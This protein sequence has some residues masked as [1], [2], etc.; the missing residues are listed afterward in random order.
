VKAI[1]TILRI[2]DLFME[3]VDQMHRD[4]QTDRQM[5]RQT[6][7]QTSRTDRQTDKQDR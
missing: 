6:D 1:K 5:D 3:R 7:R 2:M 4:I